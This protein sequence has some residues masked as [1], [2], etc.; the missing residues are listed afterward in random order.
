MDHSHVE[1]I[2]QK[3]GQQFTSLPYTAPVKAKIKQTEIK[4]LA[5]RCHV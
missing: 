5:E 2:A 1:R 3:D 4:Y